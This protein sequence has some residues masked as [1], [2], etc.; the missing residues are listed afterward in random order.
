M[1]RQTLEQSSD[2]VRE[3][4]RQILERTAEAIGYQADRDHAIEKKTIKQ[5]E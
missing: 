2:F 1:E 5:N 4:K 3:L